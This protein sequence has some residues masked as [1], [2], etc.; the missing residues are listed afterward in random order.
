MST[1]SAA[2]IIR[3]LNL[4]PLE[5]EG[6]FFRE[7][8]RANDSIAP[9]ALPSRY[10]SARGFSTAI[11]YLLTPDTFSALHQVLSDEIFHF[12]LG[13]A[14]EM[15]QLHPDGSGTIVTISNDLDLGRP[16]VIVEHG[17]WQGAHLAAGGTF[18]LLG[19]TVAPGFVYEDFVLG[20]RAELT[21][22]Y[23]K[24]ESQIKQLTL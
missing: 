16:Q 18:A 1:P 2:D 21:A 8:Y 19:C 23:P 7:T 11:Y 14:V 9:T 10:K 5:P 4:Q 17:I 12:Y 24:F 22:R 13:D 3:I 15:L 20:D 6:G